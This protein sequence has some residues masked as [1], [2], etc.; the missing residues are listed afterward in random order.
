MYTHNMIRLRDLL[1]TKQ[2]LEERVASLETRVKSYQDTNKILTDEN[3]A[4]QTLYSTQQRRLSEGTLLKEARKSAS[5]TL[6][7]ASLHC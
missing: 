5:S 7:I 6:S 1:D 2:R 3:Q 4:F